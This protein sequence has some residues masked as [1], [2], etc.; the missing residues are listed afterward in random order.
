MAVEQGLDD[1]QADTTLV[2]HIRS[3]DLF[4]FDYFN[5]S[6]GVIKEWMPAAKAGKDHEDGFYFQVWYHFFSAHPTY[7]SRCCSQITHITHHHSLLA[8]RYTRM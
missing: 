8:T 6:P 2:I 4:D 5:G 1:A 7:Q 3:G